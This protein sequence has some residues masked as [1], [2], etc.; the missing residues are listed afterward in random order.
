[1][2]PTGALNLIVAIL[3][4]TFAATVK[5]QSVPPPNDNFEDAIVLSGVTSHISTSLAG[6]T[7][8]ADEPPPICGGFAHTAWWR[9]TA[10]ADGQLVVTVKTNLAAVIIYEGT[11][12]T[13]LTVLATNT[14]A[15]I[16][17][18]CGTRCNLLEEASS[19]ARAG[20]TYYVMLDG[21][22][23]HEVDVRFFGRPAN[24]DFAHREVLSGSSLVRHVDTRGSTSEPGEPAVRY[25]TNNT[26]WFEWT[27]PISGTVAI[28]D[29]ELAP[30]PTITGDPSDG[31]GGAVIIHV[32]PCGESYSDPQ[33]VS[34]SP[35]I[36]VFRGSSLEDLSLWTRGRPVFFRVSV[37]ET[38]F[39]AATSETSARGEFDMHLRVI[40]PPDNDDF[41]KRPFLTGDSI[42]IAG[43]NVGAT[44]DWFIGPQDLPNAIN[45][46][47]VWWAWTPAADGTVTIKCTGELGLPMPLEIFDGNDV[48]SLKEIARADNNGLAMNVQAG[49][50]YNI[51]AHGRG[52]FTE[53]EGPLNVQLNCLHPALSAVVS[54]RGTNE[55]PGLDFTISG[56]VG[57]KYVIQTSIELVY[58]YAY[59]NGVLS[60]TTTI[61]VF[62]NPWEPPMKFMRLA[63]VP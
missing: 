22:G 7:L 30:I 1:V 9:F 10:P 37:G 45:R 15:V 41:A 38:Y 46:L 49:H 39:I 18:R 62:V 33:D 57:Q 29:Y 63:P 25:V 40:P 53:S 34:F 20:V 51:G 14:Y 44:A 56:A 26:V 32:D 19:E 52:Q 13:N 35:L 43:H 55:Y 8:Q 4:V 54:Q 48:R 36:G 27:A 11:T 23:N 28:S 31:G 12:L 17:G 24:D 61:P 47:G 21:W 5:G 59:F 2:S 58:W 50:T 16:T 42:Q 3:L 60:N 6:A